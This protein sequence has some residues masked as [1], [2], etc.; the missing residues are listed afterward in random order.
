MRA[1]R[2]VSNDPGNE[3][4]QLIRF[5]Q[6]IRGGTDRAP[7]FSADLAD[8]HASFKAF[9]DDRR[10]FHIE[11]TDAAETIIAEV[12]GDPLSITI[13]YRIGADREPQK[14]SFRL[15]R[16]DRLILNARGG[17]DFVNIIDATELLSAQRKAL[18]LNGGDGDNI[19]VLSH[20]PF[21]LETARQM[22]Q[23][24]YLSKQI[25]DMA[26]RASEA[27]SQALMS[28][29]MRLI[30]SNRVNLADVSKS[31]ASD[32][33]KQL[34]G[35][36]REL[37]ERSGPRLAALG[38][39]IISKSDDLAK[40][41]GR[42]VA[43]LTK[44]YA[45]TNG[46]F[47]PEDSREPLDA[48]SGKPDA[49]SDSSVEEEE[50]DGEPQADHLLQVGLKLGDDARTQVE[51]MGKQM[52][53]DAADIEQRAA[54][55]EKR[56]EQLS[57]AADLLAARGEQDM[58]AAADRV[59]AVVA[60]L[61]SLEGSF[62]EAGLA[63]R[64]EL[65]MAASMSPAASQ[66]K[67][68]NVAGVSCGTPIVT[69]NTYT[70]SGFFLPIG[71]PWSSWSIT[72]GAG[73][74]LLIGG[75]A[76]DDIHGGPGNDFVFGLSG[77]DHIHGDDGNDLLVGEFLFDVPS[78]TGDDCIWGDNGVDL[79]VGDNLIEPQGGTAGG[80][81]ELRG[82]NDIDIVVGDDLLDVP[83]FPNFNPVL[84]QIF[85]QT[86]PGGKDTIEGNDDIDLLFGGG[87]ADNIKGN[88]GMD[89][90]EG[91]GGA[92]VIEGGKGRDFSFCNTTVELGNLL[93]GGREGDKV[94]GGS[95]IDVIFGE[96]DADT[97][98]GAGQVDLMFG[99]SEK[100]KMYGDA[101]G[102]ICVLPNGIPIRL[103]NL[104]LGGT[105]DDNM[106]AGGDL[107]AMF[108]QDGDDKIYGY[109]GSF[110]QPS[111]IDADW[112]SGGNGNDYLEGDNESPSLLFSIDF[113][114]G[115][116][117]VDDMRGGKNPDFML[118][119]TG[120]DKMR[121]DSNNLILVTSMDLMFGGPDND[122]MDGGNSLDLLLGG[123]GSDTMRGDDERVL[124]ISPDLMFGGPGIDRMNGGSSL[125]FMSGE[126]DAD[127]ML[128]DSNLS[129]QPLSSDFML[130]G[131]GPDFMDGG[132]SRDLMWGGDGCDTMRGDNSTPIRISPDFMFGE[133]GNDDM[134]GGN[135]TDFISGGADSDRVV[136]DR[137][138]SSQLFSIDWLWGDDGC[139]T[140]L[141]GRALDWIFGG[142]G[143]DE[144][145][146]QRGPDL[147]SGGPG[148][149]TIN[150]GD[151][152]DLIWGDEANDLIHGNDFL[153]LIRGGDGNDCIYGDDGADSVWGNEG[154]DCIHGGNG[155]DRLRGNRDNDLIFGDNGSDR[156]R[157]GNDD[158]KLDGG[159][160]FDR[161]FG[162]S[163]NDAGWRGSGGALFFSVQ[164]R[165]SGSS[166]L[167]CNCQIDVCKGKICVHKF[168][169]F[170]GDGIQNG[171][172]PDLE[173]WAFQVMGPC[174][175]TTLMTDANGNDCGDFAGIYTVVEQMQSGWTATTPTTVTATAGQATPLIFGNKQEGN[176][177]IC[178]YKF[179]DKNGNGIRDTGEPALP[180][181]SFTVTD[182][183]GASTTLATSPSGGCASANLPAGSYTV[184]EHP[185]WFWGPTTPT[186]QTVIV[187]A[188]TTTV[189]FGNRPIKANLGQLCIYKFNDLNGNGVQDTGEQM[190]PQW[191]FTLTDSSGTSIASLETLSHGGICN[192][193]SGGTTFTVVETPQT[194]WMA[195][196]P[197]TQSVTVTA[198]Q[199]TNVTFGNQQ[200]GSNKCD[201]AIKKEAK[202]KDLV[203]G[204]EGEFIEF[205]VTLTNI[206]NVPCQGPMTVMESLH[207][208][209]GGGVTGTWTCTNTV[210]TSEE[211]LAA[212]ASASVR[213]SGGEEAAKNCVELT[214]PSDTNPA[215]NQACID[216]T[217]V[218]IKKNT[219]GGDDTFSYTTGAGLSAFSITTTGGSGS[220]TFSKVS[221]LTTVTES[222][223][224]PGWVF[225]SLVCMDPD[226]GTTVS[227]QTA[228]LD[229]DAGE[230][231]I[232]TYT[233]TK[234]PAI[235]L[236][237]AA[238]ALPAPV[239]NT[240]YSQT[241]TATGGC[242]SSFT[243][244]LTSGALPNGLTL[245]AD[246]MLTGTPTQA[247][248][249]DFTVTATDTCGCS[250]SDNYRLTANVRKGEFTFT[251]GMNEFCIWGG[252]G[253]FNSPRQIDN[254]NTGLPN[255]FFTPDNTG[256]V[257]FGSIGLCYGRILSANNNFAFKYT[258][259]ATP[260]AVLS[261]RDVTRDFGIPVP[262]SET[263]RNVFGAGLSPIGF[264]LYFRPQS[265]VKP[266]VNTS[267]GFIFFK[268]QVPRLNGAQFN[269][270]YD[271]GGG[272]QVF[273]D[274][275]RA[276][277]FG[278]KYQRLSNGG[279]ALNNPSFDGHVFSFGYSIF[280]AP[281]IVQSPRPD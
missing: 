231:V 97:L 230:T 166:G 189:Y 279:R 148:S 212:G 164:S 178:I 171:G 200:T 162:G 60:E 69:T 6:E 188:G 246:G 127:H 49:D 47:P 81:D 252:G 91:N 108:G 260:V 105:E 228:N 256:G 8:E 207:T 211:G 234:C 96:Q 167:N 181:W 33:E 263:R 225:T 255:N 58:T 180:N 12:I 129:W 132:N 262:G 274:A 159:A 119:E 235:T 32:A 187:T 267:G 24:Q 27:T 68:A 104:M 266:F 222:Q 251:R 261:Y 183:S 87:G 88:A 254:P 220:Q 78:I 53:K 144:I 86:H 80:D 244:S 4:G 179:H 26:K 90:A 214:N 153:D 29:A 23:L 147:I 59:L 175:A 155:S 138:F 55:F 245:G 156:L 176:G 151:S 128:G 218:I 242:S 45:P 143:V 19:V 35:P 100:D 240:P 250:Q 142:N 22:M 150:G 79:V 82:G 137:Q 2:V 67:V 14:S 13:E 146:G 44:K 199:A 28:D 10:T 114:I 277:T 15:D 84:L 65:L 160:G 169:D 208:D 281:K 64:E 196:T 136:G 192:T 195:T 237:A 243:Y 194:G 206:S 1:Q 221:G 134:D 39:S 66:A 193:F 40:Q 120:A 139:D 223:P 241:F 50:S 233:N 161:I 110:Q 201:L 141:G 205:I 126:D 248:S 98:I 239:V 215:N 56:M 113:I 106:W 11:G 38:D 5:S 62:R 124:L 257:R 107:D 109:D 226:G 93:L 85:S 121:G 149:D 276:F 75:F 280:R 219:V 89:F 21:K 131:P 269:F 253:P 112:I 249:Y 17:A 232:C 34:F 36:A 52:E 216:L 25:E 99:G 18:N 30:E 258:F 76:A 191:S 73:T 125:D 152:L 273:R 61:K 265:R 278:Y 117:G 247:G 224:P 197:T 118:G 186:T 31:I 94:T 140:I 177:E 20:L 157:G 3:P 165:H 172:E 203:S 213:F 57:T 182:S 163:G 16:F 229:L 238:G 217:A 7:A 133:A 72:G 158:D 271:F 92:D 227:G 70:G 264:Q 270:T 122:W 130:G 115:G 145:D 83:N 95:G 204:E 174:D 42:L 185:Q 71:A 63:L 123:D 111:A 275:R 272:V 210:C 46:S 170:N 173:N 202:P 198:G 43:E 259:N 41:Q 48:P 135:S 209:F 101:G 116:P 9:I 268:D 236:N 74:D 154:D 51:R 190:V 102:L 54:E 103:G 37:V 168:N 184:V 77:N